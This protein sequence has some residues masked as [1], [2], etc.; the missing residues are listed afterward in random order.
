LKHVRELSFS[1]AFGRVPHPGLLIAIHRPSQTSFVLPGR[2]QGSFFAV[3]EEVTSFM[4]QHG[5]AFAIIDRNFKEF[6]VQRHDLKWKIGGGI[7]SPV[8][9]IV[10]PPIIS[11]AKHRETFQNEGLATE[12][13]LL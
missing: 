12:P 9:D 8:T 4:Q 13:M 3:T 10:V 6:R 7:S 1:Q 5:R 11:A 2:A